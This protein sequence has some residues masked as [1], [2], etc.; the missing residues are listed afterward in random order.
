[1]VARDSQPTRHAS[2]SSS[3]RSASAST[4]S[5]RR[6]AR[7]GPRTSPWTWSRCCLREPREARDSA[8]AHGA[9]LL[10]DPGSLSAAVNA[11]LA[12]ADARHV[13]GNWIGDDDLLAPGSLACDEPGPRPRPRRRRCVRPL[14]VHRRRRVDA[15]GV[16]RAGRGAVWLLAWGPDL[17][18]QPGMLFRLDDFRAVGGLDESLKFAMDL[19]LLLRLRRRGRFVDVEGTG[20]LV[21]LARELD[22]GVGPVVLAAPSPS[23]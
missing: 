22:H 12:R 1:M 11:G 19:D 17:V 2:C 13:Y 9:E 16:S 4:T 3:R 18:P 6:C 21:P 10:D 8:R 14:H 5:S 23:A 20:Q 15:L 7:C